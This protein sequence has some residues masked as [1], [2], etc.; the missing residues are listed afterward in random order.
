MF[1]LFTRTNTGAIV[2]GLFVAFSKVKYV[3]SEI[4]NV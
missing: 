4:V 3:V 1:D 2:S